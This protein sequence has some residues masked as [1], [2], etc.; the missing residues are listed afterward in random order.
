MVSDTSAYTL[1]PVS[2]LDYYDTRSVLLPI[3]IPPLEAWN[4]IMEDPQPMMRVAFRIRDAIASRFGVKRIG[5]FSGAKRDAVRAGDRI[6]FFLVEHEAPGLLVLTERDRHLE[7][8]ICISSVE[9]SLTI[10]SSVVIHN[11]FGRAYMSVVGPIHK[12]LVRNDLK[13][14]VRKLERL[15]PAT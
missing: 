4:F 2:E 5:G 12:L 14:L 15:G 9:R 11:M 3:A 13:R 1:R 8:M 6:D 10:T 7:V